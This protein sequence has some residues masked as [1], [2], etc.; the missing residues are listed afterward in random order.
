MREITS[1]VFMQSS[2]RWDAA[3]LP[4]RVQKWLR[5][6]AALAALLLACLCLPA[7]AGTYTG[8]V[9][10][11][12]DGDTLTV[13]DAEQRQRKIRLA[14]IDA[15]EKRQAWGQRAHQFLGERVFQ[16]V[17]RIE[18]SK[19]DRYGREIGRVLLDGEDINLELVRA[20][21]AWHYRAY[22]REQ[23]PEER[24]LY[25]EAEQQAREHR[26]GLWSDAHPVAP[27]DFRRRGRPGS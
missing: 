20:G 25:A 21:L 14:G 18:V 22:A 7:I 1:L 19:K 16:R 2:I 6:T 8:R 9:V 26:Q 15:P 24:G 27:W 4:V 12:S 3:D 10:G 11:I 23:P 17:V 13:L 5:K